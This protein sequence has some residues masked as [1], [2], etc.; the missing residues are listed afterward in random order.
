MKKLGILHYTAPRKEVGGVEI[1]IEHHARLLAGKGYEVHLIYGSGGGLDYPGVVEHEIPA[2][3]PAITRFRR[4]KRKYSLRR[5][6]QSSSRGLK[7]G[8]KNRF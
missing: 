4:F 6:K 2:L 1:V 8:S 3:S 7:M 5:V